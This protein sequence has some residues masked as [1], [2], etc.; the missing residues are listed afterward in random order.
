MLALPRLIS[1]VDDDAGVRAALGN[2]IRSIGLTAALFATPE[3]FLQ[4]PLL[5]HTACLISD[6]EL[7]NMS[8]FALY[9]SLRAAGHDMPVIFITA[10]SDEGFR[11]RAARMGAAALFEKPFLPDAMIG[12]IAHALLTP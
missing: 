11:E 5:A 12:S 6:V 9:E 3:A 7:P 1:V 4:S 2:L 8:G 10:A